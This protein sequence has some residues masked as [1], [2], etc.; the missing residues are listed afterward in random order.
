MQD[1]KG[2]S[3]SKLVAFMARKCLVQPFCPN[4]NVPGPACQR[5]S[6]SMTAYP[7]DLLHFVV[8]RSGSL[9]MSPFSLIV[10]LLIIAFSVNF[11]FYLCHKMRTDSVAKSKTIRTSV[12]VNKEISLHF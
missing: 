12:Q 5:H 1:T 11:L 9:L 10:Y 2:H 7:Q 4:A 8:A 3:S 6:C